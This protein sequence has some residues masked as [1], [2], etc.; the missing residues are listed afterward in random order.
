MEPIEFHATNV[1]K[2]LSDYKEYVL[3]CRFRFLNKFAQPHPGN[4]KNAIEIPLIRNVLTSIG[5][6]FVLK[7]VLKKVLLHDKKIIRNYFAPYSKYTN[8]I[9]QE[10]VDYDLRALGYSFKA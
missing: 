9:L 4:G 1:L 5:K 2:N 7:N 10:F 6:L 8:T 3:L